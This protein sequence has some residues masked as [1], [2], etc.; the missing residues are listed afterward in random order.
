MDN[1]ALQKEQALRLKQIVGQTKSKKSRQRAQAAFIAQPSHDVPSATQADAAAKMMGLLDGSAM[2]PTKPH[3][4]QMQTHRHGMAAIV[5]SAGW[6]TA[7]PSDVTTESP[8]PFFSGTNEYSPNS[9]GLYRS[10]DTRPGNISPA[11]FADASIPETSNLVGFVDGDVCGGDILADF[12][13]FHETIFQNRYA[14]AEPTVSGNIMELQQTAPQR[15][16][17]LTPSTSA[18]A[19]TTVSS[20]PHPAKE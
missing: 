20:W 13:T 6:I 2:P 1:G 3:F 5:D 16:R 11:L 17:P 18:P 9:T 7:P 12:D 10:A 14:P 19:A 4:Q 8:S 15:D